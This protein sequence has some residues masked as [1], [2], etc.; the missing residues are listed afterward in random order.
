[1]KKLIL[2]SMIGI[3]FASQ[4]LPGVAEAK[5]SGTSDTGPCFGWGKIWWAQDSGAKTKGV[6]I[7]MATSNG[8]FGNQTFG[9]SSGTRIERGHRKTSGFRK[10]S[11]EPMIIYV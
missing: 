7:P 5:S 10:G 6:Q 9:I 3:F 2:L 4:G 8:M 1:M 11:V